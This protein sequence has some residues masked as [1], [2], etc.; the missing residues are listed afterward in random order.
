M[1]KTLPALAVTGVTGPACIIEGPMLGAPAVTVHASNGAAPRMSATAVMGE[2]LRLS[3]H[4]PCLVSVAGTD[5]GAQPFGELAEM[6]QRQGY[7]VRVRTA[8]TSPAG[9]FGAVDHVDVVP[10]PPS[11]GIVVPDAAIDRT[12]ALALSGDAEVA[13]VLGVADQGD[14]EYARR[15]AVQ[16]APVPAVLHPVADDAGLMDLRTLAEWTLADRWH[17][18]RVLPTFGQ[19]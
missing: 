16:H 4:F 8:G 18:A 12:L 5:P 9:W 17:I 7:A 6:F 11:S 13:L 2:V 10:P 14:Y 1:V 3:G 19:G 15:L